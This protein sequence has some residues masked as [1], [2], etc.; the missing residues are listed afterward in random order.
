MNKTL[1]VPLSLTPDEK[2]VLEK[3][4]EIAKAQGHDILLLHVIDMYQVEVA[5]AGAEL[6]VADLNVYREHLI[7]QKRQDA[8]ICLQEIARGLQEDGLT[9]IVNIEA[10]RPGQ[11]II[12]AANHNANIAR[13]I[14]GSR[15]VSTLE[16]RFRRNIAAK[17]QRKV[18]CPVT[19]VQ[20]PP[21]V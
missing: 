16:R 18:R 12:R 15:H 17:V 2:P 3:A 10:G 14:I 21:R 4:K 9:V 11:T 19:V 7:T 5:M 20:L 13:I 6:E 8:Q 1:L